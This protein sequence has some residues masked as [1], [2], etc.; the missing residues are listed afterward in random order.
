ML[1]FKVKVKMMCVVGGGAFVTLL[2]LFL[3]S[4]LIQ[5]RMLK[6]MLIGGIDARTRA[7]NINVRETDGAWKAL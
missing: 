4:V 7:V 2:L 1:P 5:G 6:I 3:M